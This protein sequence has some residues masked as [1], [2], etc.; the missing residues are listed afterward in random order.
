MVILVVVL[1]YVLVALLCVYGAHRF[2]MTFLERRARRQMLGADRFEALPRVTVQLPVFNEKFVVARLIDA[3]AALNYPRELLQIQVLDDSTDDSVDIAAARIAHFRAQ[4]L[5]I[6]H[7][8]RTDRTGYKAGA[9]AEAMKSATGEFIAIFDADFTPDPDFLMETVHHFKDPAVGMVQTRW[10]YLNTKY[11]L[12]TRVQ[13]IMLDAH[14]GTEQFARFGTDA[15]F[16]FNGTAGIWRASAIHDA[17]GW[18][19]DTLTEDLD[20]SYRAQLKGWKFLYLRDVGCPSELPIDMDAF[21]AQQHR[22]AKGAI[23]VMKKML[24]AVWASPASLHRKIEATFHLTSNFSYVLM[25][26]DSIF[27]LVPTII[28]RERLGWH[29]LSWVDIPLFFLASASYSWFFMYSQFVLYKK[30]KDKIL[31]LPA[32]LATSIGLGINNS[33]AVLEALAGH[34]TGFERTPKLGDGAM[35]RELTVQRRK[36]YKAVAKQWSDWLELILGFFYASAAI[37]A[38]TEGAWV[39]TPFLILFASGFFYTSLLSFAARRA[40]KR[41]A[42]A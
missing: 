36:A 2:Y 30:I 16:N 41:S 19:A 1:H 14:F 33:R 25:V 12:L 8:R 21:K 27:L 29:V 24:R 4:G 9:L 37:W 5:D 13:S 40:Q 20:L 11:S 35:R 15:F 38:V 7:V 18:R 10:K 34:V 26:V 23:E 17:G 42:P 22:W 3:V 32:L 39:A 31:V 6:Q 28:I